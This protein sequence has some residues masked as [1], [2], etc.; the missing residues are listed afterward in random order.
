MVAV[1]E[2]FVTLRPETRGFEREAKGSILGP[3]KGIAIAA[4]GLFAAKVGTDFFRGAIDSA[5]DLT[6]SMTKNQVVFGKVN[7]E[8]LKFSKGADA[9][10]LSDAAALKATGTFGNLFRAVGLTEE[11]S[12]KF[13]TS[14]TGLAADL[15]SFNNTSIDEALEAIRSGMVGETE[16]LKRFGVNMNEATLKAKAMALG[17]SD[18]KGVLDANVKSQA[19]Y[20]LIMEQTSLAQGDFARTS[21][22]LA[23]KQRIFGARM[24]ELK[25][26]IGA[27]L[28]PIMSSF[29]GLMT[30]K[31]LPAFDRL[32]KAAG[33]LIDKL[34]YFGDVFITAFKFGN[35]GEDVG[36]FS[37]K[38]AD[39]AVVMRKIADFIQDNLKPI[40]IGLGVAIAAL[41]SPWLVVAGA[42]VYAYVK[43]QAVRDAVQFFIDKTT[44]MVEWVKTMMPQF[45]E[46]IGH[47]VAVIQEIW[48]RWGDEIM[49]V[50][51]RAFEFVKGTI[52]NAL[53]IVRGI[54]QT[55]T[56]LINGEWGKA[57]DGF[58][59]ILAGVWDQL[60]NIVR[61]GLTIILDIVGQLATDLRDLMFAAGKK[62]VKGLIEGVK[63]AATGIPKAVGGAIGGGLDKVLPGKGLIPKFADGGV[64]PGRLGEHSLAWVA[65]GET[66]LPTHKSALSGTGSSG[67]M[68]GELHVH[69][70]DDA[71]RIGMTLN[72]T[73][74]DAA[75]QM[76]G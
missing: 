7:D 30:D 43:F 51:R 41:V 44:E 9:I 6:E 56:A 8:V 59:T 36:D 26:K 73:L 45:Q 65:G 11:Q 55:I 34:R 62:L 47:A 49:A 25:A 38:V 70:R 75:W 76:A 53:Q 19:A 23:N 72:Q 61:T 24:E 16:P 17:L 50:V 20:A 58:K 31:L 57:W 32:S 13:S 28:L 42:A 54:I 3:L 60:V 29:V 35:A 64:M 68:I 46:A 67:P 66:I 21:G 15:A 4:G 2:A 40:L 37:D 27:G 18:G 14:L 52:D 71:R 48:A 1:A 10:G 33:P 5:S 39:F 63:D 22:G 74:R 69:T 12:A